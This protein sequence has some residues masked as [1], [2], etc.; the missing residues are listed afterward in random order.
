M[1]Y[2]SIAIKLNPNDFKI[3]KKHP[4]TIEFKAACSTFCDTEFVLEYTGTELIP[5]VTLPDYMDEF[6]KEFQKQFGYG[7]FQRQDIKNKLK[8]NSEFIIP[9]EK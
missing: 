4:Y 7:P 3:R 6:K 5:K 1:A 8:E 9:M 2:T